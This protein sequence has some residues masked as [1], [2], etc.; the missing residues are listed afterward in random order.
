MTCDIFIRSYH[1][2]F[3]WLRYCLR[4]IRKHGRGFR[5]VLLVVPPSSFK[6]A[7]AFFELSDAVFCGREYRDDYLGQQVTKLYADEYT[8]AD[9]ICH[10]DSDYL[11]WRE[12]TAEE[13]IPGG[14][15]LI[16]WTP[17]S[18]L[19]D[20]SVWQRITETFICEQVPGNFMRRP[21]F[22]FPRWLYPRL[23]DYAEQK[24]A[25]SIDNYV[26]SQPPRG[27][28]EF[29]A[30]AAYAFHFHRDAFRWEQM[31]AHDNNETFCKWY[32]SL[33]GL[34]PAIRRQADAILGGA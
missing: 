4:S 22:V 8:D 26:M 18:E 7:A 19:P 33:G 9:Y 16:A 12:L 2:D 29:N 17:Y 15:P 31:R 6:P 13:L 5:R 3:E 24:H 11:F 30:L 20:D 34:T 27:F 10:V 25:Q 32:W 23:R 1:K 14:T 28:S 21:P